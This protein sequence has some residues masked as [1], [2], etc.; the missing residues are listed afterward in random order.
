MAKQTTSLVIAGGVFAL[1][2]WLVTQPPVPKLDEAGNLRCPEG[3]YLAW[4]V[5]KGH[6]CTKELLL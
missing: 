2:Y 4:S 1:I 3:W 5:E 6:F